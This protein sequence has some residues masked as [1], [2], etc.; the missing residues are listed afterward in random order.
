MDWSQRVILGAMLLFVC[1]VGM[2]ALADVLKA[3]EAR[4]E[5][6]EFFELACE[7]RYPGKPRTQKFCV[8]KAMA[9]WISEGEK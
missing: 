2:I 8:N 1:L 3:Q 7:D 5:K 9:K 6:R 4:Q